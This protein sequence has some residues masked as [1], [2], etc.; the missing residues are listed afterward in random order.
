MKEAQRF[1][2]YVI[3]G[4]VFIIEVSIYLLISANQDF[5][6]LIKKW[7]TEIT[8]ISF[9]ISVFLASGGIG[10]WFGIFYRVLYWSRDYRI[11]VFKPLSIIPIVNHSSL[12][13]DS[14]IRNFLVLRSSDS[15]EVN[16]NNISQLEAMC[17]VNAFW[18][19][20]K[21]SSKKIK[22]ANPFVD[23]LTDIMH[24]LG[25]AYIGS[26]IAILVWLLVI[27][28][29]FEKLVET[30]PLIVASFISV[31]IVI[32]HYVNYRNVVT[33][34]QRVVNIIVADELE[35]YFL[36]NP[37]PT[38]INVTST[39]FRNLRIRRRNNEP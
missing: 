5:I 31:V 4:L 8:S 12:I 1:L 2:R 19:E 23:R 10:F 30:R 7:R 6:D 24:G 22:E 36:N 18:N 21:E 13:K 34:V 28:L 32:I 20:R 25:A 26:I 11:K 17:I 3:P 35:E 27:P 38:I 33:N 16:P 9:V 37:E 39:D 15:K 29:V 14:V